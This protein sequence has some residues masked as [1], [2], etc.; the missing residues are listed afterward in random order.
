MTT[1]IFAQVFVINRLL[2]CKGITLNDFFNQIPKEEK[3]QYT[4]V[5]LP[6]AKY[7]VNKY[8]RN[9]LGPQ[10]TDIKT[11]YLHAKTISSVLATFI[12]QYPNECELVTKLKSQSIANED[13]N[14]YQRKLFNQNDVVPY[15]F[16][17]ITLTDLNNCSI[18]NSIWLINA[19]SLHSICFVDLEDIILNENIINYNMCYIWQR[20]IN[21]K[22]VDFYRGEEDNAIGK[23][24]FEIL[25][26]HMIFFP[27]IAKNIESFSIYVWNVSTQFFLQFW[28]EKAI[29][30]YDK[31]CDIFN[32]VMDII[33]QE[34]LQESDGNENNNQDNN[35]N[36]MNINKM[37]QFRIEADKITDDKSKCY[38]K[39]NRKFYFHYPRLNLS[40]CC[41]ATFN[42]ILYPIQLSKKCQ[43]LTIDRIYETINSRWF[44]DIINHSDLSG[45]KSLTMNVRSIADDIEYIEADENNR[46]E[47]KHKMIEQFARKFINLKYID[48]RICYD[49]ILI[50][51]QRLTDINIFVKNEII[52][53]VDLDVTS[54]HSN[55]NENRLLQFIKWI[56]RNKINNIRHLTVTAGDSAHVD[57]NNHNNAT[58]INSSKY[59]Y[60]Y[61]EWKPLLNCKEIQRSIECLAVY[62]EN[63]HEFEYL[64]GNIDYDY[65][66]HDKKQK[67]KQQGNNVINK[68][69]N[70]NNDNIK[71]T[72]WFNIEFKS[73][74]YIHFSCESNKL[75]INV[76]TFFNTVYNFLKYNFSS[77]NLC[78]KSLF[79][80]QWLSVTSI[81]KKAS[82]IENGLKLLYDII[83]HQFIL[84]QI[85]IDIQIEFIIK[86]IGIDNQEFVGLNKYHR[87]LCRMY[88]NR[89][90]SFLSNSFN[91]PQSILADMDDNS[92]FYEID[93]S[94][95]DTN[96]EN[97]TKMQHIANVNTFYQNYKMAK[98]NKYCKALLK[99]QIAF[100]F[101]NENDNEN[102][103][104]KLSIHFI[105]KTANE[106]DYLSLEKFVN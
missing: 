98:T 43:Y 61:K 47:L 6:L 93:S 5:L 12:N 86:S 15:L 49:D 21:V 68:N 91:I 84:T 9:H 92:Q 75:E 53:S 10:I 79:I 13:Q 35:S 25:E 2:D 31:F 54:I 105:V 81:T 94:D 32:K 99:P 39:Y 41:E 20:F 36:M 63:W 58:N 33:A 29:L 87:R 102:D 22:Y 19:Y 1:C 44:K 88:C 46:D 85:P 57:G 60:N 78:Y 37:K 69:S 3:K 55:S 4:D 82:E 24:S 8:M 40:N 23:E 51:L 103:G 73:L 83:Y 67:Q 14:Y 45:I 66:K 71:R 16:Q 72:H 104:E 52:M 77:I 28:M 101:V 89:F 76:S 64:F 30:C 50:F 56:D 100:K 97:E 34:Q 90:Q 59:N 62:L 95:S 65:V 26:K 96:D 106:Q 17:Y 18:V 74:R 48:I 80:R 70:Y 11:L 42:R 38:E 27:L 7:G